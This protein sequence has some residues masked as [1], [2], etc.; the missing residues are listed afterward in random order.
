MQGRMVTAAS[1]QAERLEKKLQNALRECQKKPGNKR[2]ADCIERLPQWVVTD[3]NTFV[4]TACSGIHREFSHRVKSI[5]LATFTEDEVKGVKEGGNEISNNLY[6]ARYRPGH[7]LPEPEG[8]KAQKHRDFIRTKYVDKR[9]YGSPED[10]ERDA[11]REEEREAA[12]AKR[13]AERSSG[14]K[15]G[16]S[17]AGGAAASKRPERG[18]SSSAA[19]GRTRRGSTDR[20]LRKV[21]PQSAMSKSAAAAAAAPVKK[22]ADLLDFLT[23]DPAPA[24]PVAAQV[25]PA[26]AQQ[27]D[28]FGGGGGGGV[29]GAAAQVPS[30][31]AGATAAAGGAGFASWAAF[32]NAPAPAAPLATP[33]GHQ[34]A[35]G[36]PFQDGPAA[37]SGVG[38]SFPAS[39]FPANFP[40]PPAGGGVGT[41]ASGVAGGVGGTMPGG[42]MPGAV[43]PAGATAGV[44]LTTGASPAPSPSGGP[45]QGFAQMPGGGVGRGQSRW[46]DKAAKGWVG[47]AT[48]GRGIA[49]GLWR[50]WRAASC[51]C[52]EHGLWMCRRFGVV[53]VVPSF[54]RAVVERFEKGDE[55]LYVRG[56]DPP[57]DGVVQKVHVEDDGPP[58]YTVLIAVT[59]REKNTDHAHLRRKGQAGALN[60]RGHQGQ[61]GQQ[62]AG[63]D[64]FSS[65]GADAWGGHPPLPTPHAPPPPPPTQAQTTPTPAAPAAQ[66]NV[67]QQA[68]AEPVRV[69]PPVPPKPAR[70]SLGGELGQGQG[71]PSAGPPFPEQAS[72]T[73]MAL[74]ED[75]GSNPF[76]AAAA[77]GV[78]LAQAG[79]NPF[80][81][82]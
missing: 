4:C 47:K 33:A 80:D 43:S 34:S 1:R 30:S 76:A 24:A 32:G 12:K 8:G 39:S 66:L 70:F 49:A 75:A 62:P 60:G 54:V 79:G 41:V 26:G 13:D 9:W 74:G 19:G 67:P 20:G 81:M 16:S 55:V 5:S 27:W 44:A 18:S 3:F 59:G 38:A 73:P 21:D 22:Q 25:P 37:P 15:G 23:D 69:P 61:Q 53:G 51:L 71:M 68:Q 29:G 58:Y 40:P 46:E 64:A 52:E 77:G 82:F 14:K 48:G 42:A 50:A 31:G 72:A 63:P 6:M 57:L 65:L 2:C 36:F 45:P 17:P 78:P 11:R 28:A 10:V 7:D 56:T 35:V